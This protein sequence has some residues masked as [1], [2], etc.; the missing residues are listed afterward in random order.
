ML[1]P[2]CLVPRAIGHQ[3]PTGCAN[4]RFEGVPPPS[5]A[6]C[7]STCLMHQNNNEN[8]IDPGPHI[9]LFWVAVKNDPLKPPLQGCDT[10][11]LRLLS[12]PESSLTSLVAFSQTDTCHV[13][14][15]K[16][17]YK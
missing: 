8:G 15:Q 14:R 13:I 7:S 9:L 10:V 4:G 17:I 1:V 2:G 6:C 5:A 16:S 12:D 3:C 11:L